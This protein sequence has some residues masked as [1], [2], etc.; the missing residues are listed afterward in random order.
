MI[1]RKCFVLLLSAVLLPLGCGSGTEIDDEALDKMAGGK[2]QETVAVSGK[3]SIGGVPTS[4]IKIYA[5]TQSSGLKPAAETL[6]GP[7]G[8]YC[9]N[10]YTGCDGLP[11]G[12]YK[13]A[14]AHVPEEG[15][16]KKQGKDLLEG[17]Y[18][19]PKKSEFSLVV[20]SGTPQVDVNYDLK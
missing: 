13:L 3:V 7:D 17:K 4:D 1:S 11:P 20:T 16:G 12:E 9:W 19:D 14:F 10:T 5:Y 2:R 18:K 15:K 8:V 6:T